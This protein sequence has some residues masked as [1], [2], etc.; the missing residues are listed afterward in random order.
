M[1]DS[2]KRYREKRNFD[3]TSEPADGV[4]PLR[5]AAPSLPG[6]KA[7]LPAT[8]K[9]QL[10]TLVD[11][12]PRNAG[13]WLFEVKYDGY[14]ML[15][16]KDGDSVKL[17]TRN[18]ND[19]THKLQH[20]ADAIGKLAHTSGWLDGEVVVLDD[21]GVP[22]FQ[23]LQ[24]AFDGSRTSSIVFYLFDVP[25]LEGRDLRDE[26]L[27]TRRALLRQLLSEGT[28]AGLRFSDT[29]DARPQDLVASACKMGL[30]GI[31]GKLKGA[32]Y[33]SRR[34]DSWIKLKCTQRQE[35]V[36]AGYT[37]PKG[38]RTGLGSLLLAVH[39]DQG[40]LQ[41]AGNVG[42]GFDEKTL[43]S[44]KK[45]LDAVT[46]SESPLAGTTDLDRKAHWVKPVLLAEVSF[47]EWT[48]SGRIRHSVFHGLRS[49]KKPRAITREKP[50]A[51]KTVAA[52]TKTVAAKTKKVAAKTKKV[53]AK[54]VAADAAKNATTRARA[55][56]D[57]KKTVTTR[58]KTSVSSSKKSAAGTGGATTVVKQ[59]SAKHPSL[60]LTHPERVIDAST[61][62]TKLDLVRFYALVS[63]LLLPH[64]KARPVSLVRAP[65]GIEGELF[66]QK[67]LEGKMPGVK[68][69]DQSLDPEHP[70]LIEVPTV[71]ALLSAAQ[72]NVVEFHTWNAVKTAIDKPDRMTFDL[73][74][75]EGVQWKSMQQAA[76]L[77]RALLRELGLMSFVKTSGGKGLH[78]VVPLKKQYDWD[79]VR[80]F[81]QAIVQHLA[82][83]IPQVFV[84]KSG[85]KN[86]V[87][88]IFVDYLRN[89]FGATTASAWSARA[90]PGLG[91][92]VPLEWEEIESIKSG[93]Y[94]T[95]SN[96]QTR[97]DKGNGPWKDYS[98]QGIA[99][100]MKT[101]GF[102]PKANKAGE[103]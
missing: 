21:K 61:G 7:A 52:K 26:P 40:K 12:V 66:F 57:S 70:S 44:L 49:D 63:S 33:V 69:L 99:R 80:S 98:P 2:L 36:I 43:V 87:G 11:G 62:L 90:R 86:R 72:M 18:G 55:S 85:P 60:H 23:R 64:L 89:G 8:L 38:G 76:Q 59:F 67:H 95:V 92:S 68:E 101:L 79:A 97:L 78:V 81:S 37:D 46:A 16:R 75:G 39:D 14:R 100:A 32:P 31:I 25:F 17:F 22:S 54:T 58:A 94:W 4:V 84:A 5:K 19:W 34:S 9:P 10:A 45:S 77:V 74:P 50:V 15:A 6:E 24:N 27:E 83:T 47:G 103:R 65:D 73:D 29:F 88:K 35:F 20:I 13:D 1:T 3:V 56:A 53:A 42:T 28:P 30:E 82:H 48:P 102:D 51:A 41:Y 91:V 93:A 71:Q 96:I